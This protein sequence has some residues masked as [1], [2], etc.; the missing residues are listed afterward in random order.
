M[1]V[2]EYIRR[3]MHRAAN[4]HAEAS[5]LTRQIDEWFES[6]GYS[7]E[8]LRCGDGFSLEEL[9]YGNDVTDAFCARIESGEFLDHLMPYLWL[10]AGSAATTFQKVL[11]ASYPVRI[12]LKTIFVAEASERR[13][14]EANDR[15]KRWVRIYYRMYL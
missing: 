7:V 13:A 3:K 1:K 4:L 5:V 9:D 15:K 8:D 12:L 6:R 11:F 14:Y 10:G 2:P